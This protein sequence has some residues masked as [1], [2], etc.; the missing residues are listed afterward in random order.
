MRD[1]MIPL[2]QEKMLK[3]KIYQRKKVPR[4]AEPFS[5]YYKRHISIMINDILS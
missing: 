4:K 1:E 2:L 5:K 3:N